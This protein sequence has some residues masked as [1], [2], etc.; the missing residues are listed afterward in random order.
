MPA[1]AARHSP[2]KRKPTRAQA[3][4]SAGSGPHLA[5][6]GALSRRVP[7]RGAGH[8]AVLGFIFIEGAF[9]A[10]VRQRGGGGAA[11][12]CA[13][14]LQLAAVQHGRWRVGTSAQWGTYCIAA[15]CGAK[16][17]ACCT[18]AGYWVSTGAIETVSYPLPWLV[19]KRAG[20]V[21]KGSS[22]CRVT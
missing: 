10:A 11:M 7:A 14:E 21:D 1:K 6:L 12:G 8:A 2:L 4:S 22:G 15:G 19:H 13:L 9:W 17:N 3:H 5:L 16:Q 18:A 20:C